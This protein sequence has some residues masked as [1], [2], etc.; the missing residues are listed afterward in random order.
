MIGQTI[1]HYR[2]L[3]QLGHGGMG[4]VYVAEDTHLGRRVA[5]KFSSA[6]PENTQFRARFLREA[7]AA[8][9]LNHPHI[10]SIYDYGETPEGHPFIVMELVSG[11]DLFH[12]LRSGPMPV[13]Q[14]LRIV[15]EV[16]EALG[17]AHR[18]G[19]AH[20]D[21]K[22]SNIVLGERGEVKVLDFGLAKQM[23]EAPP[24][25]DASTILTSATMEGTI[26]GTPQYMSPEQ[27]KDLP[28]GPASDLFSL[29][30]VLYECLAGQP[31]FT[32][33]NPVEILAA[34]LHVDPPPP[35]QFNPQVTPEMDRIALKA[36]AKQPEAR[37]QSADEM[38]ADLRAAGRLGPDLAPSESRETELLAVP[39]IPTAAAS[40]A[41]AARPV[42]RRRVVAM[43]AVALLAAAVLVGWWWLPARRYRPAPDA[44]R[45][46]QEGVTALRDGTYY[47]ASKAL[48]RAASS[49][50][51]FSMAHA[52][53]AE[54]WLEL[55]YADQAKEEMLR[56]APP[57]AGSRLS[58]VEQLYLEAL[59][60]TMTDDFAGAVEKYRDIVRRTPEEDKAN[61]YVDLGRA[62]EKNEKL[63][64]AVAS[65]QEAT[66][67]QPQ[68]P[69]AWLRLAILDGRQ[70]DQAKAAAAFGEAEPLY[71]SLSNLEGVTE[72]LYQRA[73]LANRLGKSSEA[74]ALL[75]Q[76]LDMCKTTGNLHQHILVLLQLSNTE[77]RMNSA[78]AQDYANEAIDL[79]RANGLENLTTR[80]LIDLGNAYFVKGENDEAGKYFAQ[81][82]EYARRYKSQRNQ[83]RAMLSLGSL[84]LQRGETGEGLR[85]V[86][87]ALEW[88]Q[89]GGYQ[90]ETAQ[91]LIL[92][93]R[94]QREKGD[95]Q[96]ALRSFQQQL[97]IGRKLGDQT[98]IVLAQQGI[99]SVL[100]AQERWPDAWLYYHEAYA[101]A[102]QSGDQLNV[103][104]SLLDAGGI[105]WQLGRYAEAQQALETA[106]A[107]ASRG[108]QQQLDAVRCRMALS[109]RQ[110]AAAVAC[111]R[112]LLSQAGLS[113]EA[114]AEVGSVLGLALAAT[115]A[116][117][118]AVASTSEAVARAVKVGK[119]SLIAEAGLAQAE[120][121]LAEGDARRALDT[122]LAAQP[123]LARAGR[124]EAEWR[125]WL[126]ASRAAAA[127]AGGAK[128]REYAQQASN[129][130]AGLEQKWHSDSYSTYL[131]RPDIQ[132]ARSQLARLAGGR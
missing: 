35:S 132:Y 7:R 11:E 30:A 62:C 60:L 75:Q 111:G 53:L 55:D 40:A 70:M 121:L 46:Y 124:Q 112:R 61:A 37:Y 96:T 17:E 81:A 56:A 88:Y 73:V 20:R 122:A 3:N 45:W 92:M 59:H 57:G 21:I 103:A 102:K 115:G 85:N 48:E 47:K 8:S 97:E 4:V 123:G 108:L 118:E 120:A 125:C 114:A 74:Q 18:Q 72:V 68:N 116:R 91:A 43:A 101:A 52:R 79:A 76:A 2:I 84:E 126:V 38:A 16:A 5:V 100:E 110:F 94:A 24:S 1:S 64:E 127:L 31:A 77:H 39:A 49:D 69:A 6:S 12:V 130:L 10:A 58:G 105:L 19:I 28:L 90:K 99:G 15:E 93:G 80:G 71:R 129:L 26:L 82:L 34:V 87:Q 29:G 119:P 95:Y 44:L 27:A 23:Q 89:R 106:G 66:R 51:R 78:K 109:Q 14:S 65:Y 32:G 36:L 128:S 13:A 42:R 117:R 104:Y 131:A 33:A 83:A 41:A 63:K 113:D 9:A 54:A 50:S 107:G 25:Q 86:E 67:R 22:P 98:Q